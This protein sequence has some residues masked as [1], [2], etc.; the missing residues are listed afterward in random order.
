MTS[1]IYRRLVAHVAVAL[2]AAV[3]LAGATGVEAT[4]PAPKGWDIRQPDR[5]F[6]MTFEEAQ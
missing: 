6:D 2:M 5:T 4:R 3:T 1:Q